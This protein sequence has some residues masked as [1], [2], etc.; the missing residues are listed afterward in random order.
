MVLPALNFATKQ[1]GAGFF[2]AL[3]K[4]FFKKQVA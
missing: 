1:F 4:V 3:W 2:M